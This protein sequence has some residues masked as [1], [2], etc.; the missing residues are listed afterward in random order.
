M[1]HSSVLEGYPNKPTGSSEVKNLEKFHSIRVEKS[2]TA[3]RVQ[4]EQNIDEVGI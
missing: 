4:E 3:R 1:S 2:L